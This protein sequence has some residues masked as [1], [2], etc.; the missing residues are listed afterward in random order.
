MGDFK[1]T[2]KANYITLSI[3]VNGQ[4]HKVKV[5]E[6]VGIISNEQA[7]QA[8]N[9]SLF[10]ME[11]KTETKKREDGT[12]YKAGLDIFTPKST[13]EIKMTEAEF[14]LFKNIADN[15]NEGNGI[16]LSKADITKAQELFKQGKFTEDI[17]KNLP[18]GYTG[19]KEDQDRNTYSVEAIISNYSK[20]KEAV[21]K[22]LGKDYEYD[23]A[24]IKF[25]NNIS[26]SNHAIDTNLE[27]YSKLSVDGVVKREYAGPGEG[28]SWTEYTYTDKSGNIITMSPDY[29]GNSTM[30]RKEFTDSD[31]KRVTECYIHDEYNISYQAGDL[32]YNSDYT[33]YQR[34]DSRINSC[35]YENSYFSYPK[36]KVSKTSDGKEV[37]E[38]YKENEDNKVVLDKIVISYN[39]NGK[40]IVEEHNSNGDLQEKRVTYKENGKFIIEKHS[41]NDEI[42]KKIVT[43][44]SKGKRFYEEYDGK[45]NLTEKFAEY[46]NTKGKYVYEKYDSN[47]KLKER[48]SYGIDEYY[49]DGKLTRKETYDYA[50]NYENGKRTSTEISRGSGSKNLR[51]TID[52]SGKKLSFNGFDVQKYRDQERS[53]EGQKYYERFKDMSPKDIA[54]KIKS[55]IDGPSLNSDTLA[56]VEGIPTVKLVSVMKEYAETGGIWFGNK[57]PLLTDLVNEWNMKSDDLVEIARRAFASYLMT[58]KEA[59]LQESDANMAEKV[60]KGCDDESKLKE[61]L[62]SVE[63][64]VTK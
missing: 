3:N 39:N 26:N 36:L 42:T 56:I 11:E 8:K 23:K 20:D 7:W 54:K 50:F 52:T 34:I 44:T 1:M 22:S 33:Y 59:N 25:Y 14:A 53:K 29:D 60:L 58:T 30:V 38:I 57:A 46:M 43:Y 28:E 40:S 16:I 35:A 55:Q 5:Q 64:H 48:S 24:I 45:N 12:T 27:K 47:D 63:K 32:K 15:T 37:A 13:A 49:T 61:F 2:G 4:V 51:T 9:G 18:K 6:G 62:Q 17:T 31:G 41:S 19:A 10:R 21:A